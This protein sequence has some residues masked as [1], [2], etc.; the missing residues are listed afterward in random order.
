MGI[1]ESVSRRINLAAY[2]ATLAMGLV[3]WMTTAISANAAL[4]ADYQ[5]QNT[6]ASSVGA[7]PAMTSLGVGTNS[8]ATESVSG[9]SQTVLKFP[10]ENGVQ[11]APTAG[12]IPNDNY[13]LVVL[14]R[15]AQVTDSP[16]QRI[17][18]F[19]NGTSDRG[20]YSHLG[21]LEL[22]PYA[23]GA[24][25]AIKAEEYVLVVLTRDGAGTV[26]GYVDGAK[27]F[28]YDDSSTDA[29]VIDA[30]D[31]LRFFRDNESGGFSG[32][33]SAGAV[34]RIQLYDDALTAEQVA[35]LPS[36]PPTETGTA[37]ANVGN[38][39]FTA[40]PLGTLSAPQ[41]VVV[42]NTGHSSLHIQ[43][44][45]MTGADLN[46]FLLSSDGCSYI[47]LLV[48]ESCST[49]VRFVPSASNQRS[50]TLSVPSTDPLSPLMIAMF[51][52]GGRTSKVIRCTKPIGNAKR[53][54]RAWTNCAT[55]HHKHR[56]THGHAGRGHR[57]GRA[58]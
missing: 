41:T 24:T 13:T 30:N 12:V 28:S 2:C 50:A 33:S 25:A 38:V 6:L 48:G 20:L 51:G 32:E 11:L 27:Q 8:F 54:K 19:Q 34:A 7:P 57:V 35:N 46:D 53:V 26:T 23:K 43:R 9:S 40:Q 55:K 10:A 1:F 44:V 22:Y 16:W 56:H 3:G 18:D 4:R 29:A 15:F 36:V 49:G 5:F 31:R 42:T 58:R 21:S 47:T 45:Q 37:S 52:I 39:W 14:F 17:V